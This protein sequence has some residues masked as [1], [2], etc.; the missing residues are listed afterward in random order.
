MMD[1][2]TR[3]RCESGAIHTNGDDSFRAVSRIKVPATDQCCEVK[4]RR[5]IYVPKR[6]SESR[7][8]LRQIKGAEKPRGI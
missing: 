2:G 1:V 3:P 5:T 4:V 6:F 7:T 8:Q